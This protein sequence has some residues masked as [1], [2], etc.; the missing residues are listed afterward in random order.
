MFMGTITST[1]VLVTPNTRGKITAV[2]ALAEDAVT[3]ALTPVRAV[4]LPR[5]VRTPFGPN[6]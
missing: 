4:R 2:R 5:P 6:A 3:E 1:A